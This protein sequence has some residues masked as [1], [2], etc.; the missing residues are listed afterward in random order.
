VPVPAD[1]MRRA[2]AEVFARPEYRWNEGQSLGDWAMSRWRMLQQWL[3][4]LA[5]VN[6]ALYRVVLGG[7]L[8]VLLVLCVHVA[9]VLWQVLRPP[10]GPGV[11]AV[12]ARPPR[13]PAS[14]RARADELA[15]AGQYVDALAQR[16]VATLLD[17]ERLRAVVFHPAKTPAE[18]V[19]EARLD[20]P[21]RESLAA[22][23]AGLY[24]HVFGARPC[25]AQ[26]YRAFG[27]A[28]DDLLRHVTPG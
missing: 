24:R 5:T 4:N 2:L 3:E 22:L 7:L 19:D 9:Y 16:F 8:V 1:T 14:A 6:P 10:A 15:A 26:A 28:A 21:G 18:Y 17:L 27:A 23:V 11:V 25:D 12:P 13:H 20:G